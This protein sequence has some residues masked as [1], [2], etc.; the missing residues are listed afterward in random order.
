MSLRHNV[1]PVGAAALAIALAALPAP[2]VADDSVALARVARELGFTYA[3]LPYENAVSLSRPGATIVVRPGDAFFT[4]NERREPV[5]GA[6]PV[7]R[8]N[9]VYVSRAFMDEIRGLGRRV[10]PDEVTAAAAAAASR[11]APPVPPAGSVAT[12][13]A[14]YD[15]RD[16]RAVVRGTATPGSIVGV[17]LRAALSESLP[18]IALDHTYVVA[19]ADGTY[20]ARLSF[21]ADRFELSRYIV[22]AYGAQNQRPIVAKVPERRTPDARTSADDTK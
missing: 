13:V 18:V 17:T 5:Y 20:A 4:A 16:D 21:G 9:D 19:A 3:Y 2:A 22:E 10:D 7:Y 12:A 15:P 14:S 1:T 8:G 6:V 11:P